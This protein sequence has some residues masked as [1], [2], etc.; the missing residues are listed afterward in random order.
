[1]T[2]KRVKKLLILAYVMLV[3][4]LFLSWFLIRTTTS[5]E[6]HIK[7]FFKE[8]KNSMDVAFIGSSEM[9]ADYC[10]PLAYDKYGYT[11]YNLC[12]E[13]AP[14]QLYPAM[15]ETYLSRQ[16]PQLFV[17]EINGYLYG[18][19]DCLH[20]ANYRRL[21][22]N[23]PMSSLKIDLIEKYAPEDD[24]LSFYVPLIKHHENWKSLSYQTYRAGRL[25]MSDLSGPARL[26]AF[27][28]RTTTDS[29]V[30]T[31]RKRKPA[32]LSNVGRQALYDT[33]ELL[34]EKGV[35]NVLFLR[36]P[37]KNPLSEEASAEVAKAAADAGFDYLDC[38]DISDTEIGIDPKTDYYNR[39]HLNSIGCEKFTDFLGGYITS[40]YDIS[41]DH[42]DDVD[43]EW[44]ESADFAKE[45]FVD[46]KERTLR[47]E[48]EFYFEGDFEYRDKID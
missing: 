26:K 41:T 15:I 44:K 16:E 22:D 12:Y 17:I 33:I 32:K 39:E 40:H 7:K 36:A 37:H 24:K 47:E 6:S 14:G 43:E 42:S 29:K 9:Y 38:S 25:I 30:S 28:T 8:P 19:D 2:K 27:S 18:D 20:D 31:I 23:I 13:G 10:A 21:I 48:D 4:Y 1:M 3:V 5:C 34:Q 46:L 11:G 35:K 45:L